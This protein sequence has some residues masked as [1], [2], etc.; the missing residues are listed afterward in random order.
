MC[1]S[2]II[3]D[4]RD[5]VVILMHTKDAILSPISAAPCIRL[6]SVTAG[7]VDLPFGTLE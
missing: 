7:E 1:N 3:D 6:P 4:I 5:T 2:N